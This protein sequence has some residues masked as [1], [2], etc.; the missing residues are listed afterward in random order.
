MNS[1]VASS[2]SRLLDSHILKSGEDTE[3]MP[4]SYV[5]FIIENDVMKGNQSIYQIEGYV[6]IGKRK[7]CLVMA[8]I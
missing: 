4:D 3:K 8:R 7:Y 1:I 5:I 6:T 2:N